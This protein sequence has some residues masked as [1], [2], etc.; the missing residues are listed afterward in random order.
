[1][2]SN[3]L[4]AVLTAVKDDRE[5]ERNGVHS[6]LSYRFFGDLDYSGDPEDWKDKKL[7]IALGMAPYPS[8]IDWRYPPSHLG[9]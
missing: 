3:D 1:M 6:L 4:L 9:L 5:G 8:P 2:G 7:F